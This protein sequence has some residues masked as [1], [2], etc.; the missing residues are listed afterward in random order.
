VDRAGEEALLSLWRA[1]RRFL[2]ASPFARALCEH[3]G[4]SVEGGSR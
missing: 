1:H 4:I 3:L 2:C